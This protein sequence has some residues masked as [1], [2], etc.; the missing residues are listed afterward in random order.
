MCYYI[1]RRALICAGNS[2]NRGVTNLAKSSSTATIG[3][4]LKL[5]PV[6][7]PDGPM[8]DKLLTTVTM[9]PGGGSW[10]HRHDFRFPIEIE[11]DR[12]THVRGSMIVRLRT[13]GQVDWRTVVLNEKNRT[14]DIPPGDEHCIY[15]ASR[16]N[17]AMFQASTIR[18]HLIR[19]ELGGNVHRTPREE[20]PPEV[21]ARIVAGL[22]Q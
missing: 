10:P 18:A 1:V 13:P 9:T 15:T 21:E 19:N 2:S 16:S 12:F 22:I 8:D 17:G 11:Q 7:N 3:A 6:P 4:T 14:I 20:V 5:N